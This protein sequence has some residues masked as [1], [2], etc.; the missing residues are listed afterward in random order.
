MS[1]NDQFDYQI[2]IFF[3]LSRFDRISWLARGQKYQTHSGT[4]I[5]NSKMICVFLVI[6][7]PNS[8]HG[9]F[10]KKRTQFQSYFTPYPMLARFDT[11]AFEKSD[12]LP[13]YIKDI[14]EFRA[15]LEKYF[16]KY[17]DKFNG[18]ENPID[19]LLCIVQHESSFNLRA[20]GNKNVQDKENE[21]YTSR[22]FGILQ[23]SECYW[24]LE[25][26]R[27]E[28]K[29]FCQKKCSDFLD[30]NLSDDLACFKEVFSELIDYSR[31]YLGIKGFTPWT[32][33]VDYCECKAGKKLICPQNCNRET[34]DCN[35]T[36]CV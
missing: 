33:W 13:L 28:K 2:K 27:F 1:F 25:N 11:E 9:T 12:L 26:K 32:A 17:F 30:E 22:D 14:C 21:C 15:M 5:M 24:C 31:P 16:G 6:L 8:I 10:Y 4:R 29:S 18:T 23:F 20:V 19:N 3:Y 7:I 36:H 34:F 35:K